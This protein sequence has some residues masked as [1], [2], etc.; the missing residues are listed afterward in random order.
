MWFFRNNS[1]ALQYCN[2]VLLPSPQVACC[3]GTSRYLL[4]TGAATPRPG[5][6]APSLTSS[7]S[8]APRGV[9]P[10]S[11]TWCSVRTRAG[12]AWMF[13]WGGRRLWERWS[14]HQGWREK[15]NKALERHIWTFPHMGLTK[16]VV[17]F[18]VF[19]L[20]TVCSCAVAHHQVIWPPCPQATGNIKL[21]LL[22]VNTEKTMFDVL[23]TMYNCI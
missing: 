23:H 11:Q 18:D 22:C 20:L 5:A 3:C 6:P 8:E 9:R 10:S 16:I 12:T 19:K 13:R 4:C 14:V 15:N 7:V 1:Y 21:I 17:F 2:G